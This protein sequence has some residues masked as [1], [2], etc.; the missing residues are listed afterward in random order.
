MSKA[1]SSEALAE[2]AESIADPTAQALTLIASALVAFN[3]ILERIA[4]AME[5]DGGE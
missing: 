3:G 1:M 4:V 2:A 5:Q